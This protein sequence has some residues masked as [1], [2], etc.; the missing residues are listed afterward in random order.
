MNLT[1]IAI[2]GLMPALLI[3]I[4]TVLMR[5]SVGAGAS[6]PAYLACVGTTVALIGWGSV[7]M[8]GGGVPGPKAIILACGMGAAW[9]VSIGCIAYGLGTLRLPLSVVAP[10]TN[11]NALVGVICGALV[12]SEW[13]HL[14]MPMV[15][16]GALMICGGATLVS[17]SR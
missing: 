3:G 6:I 12:Y 17:L 1:S 10:I 5:G 7:A 16:I 2:G 15:A 13:K 8:F 9:A 11:S 14:N 4:G